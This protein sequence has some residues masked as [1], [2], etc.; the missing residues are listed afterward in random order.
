MIS[1]PVKPTGSVLV[2]DDNGNH[3][4]LQTAEMLAE[5]GAAV[6]I[7]TPERFFAPEI[8]G[9]NHAIYARAFQRH[10]VRI[11]INSA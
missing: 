9:L 1:G 4:G 3:P 2:Y 5:A 7:V 11:T 6:E 8:G 10:S